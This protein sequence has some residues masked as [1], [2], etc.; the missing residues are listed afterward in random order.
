MNSWVEAE[1]SSQINSLCLVIIYLFKP[2]QPFWLCRV[3]LFP[4]LIWPI[5]I[6]Y[7]WNCGKSWM[8]L[9]RAKNFFKSFRSKHF[10]S[11]SI[12]KNVKRLDAS[13]DLFVFFIVL[14]PAQKGRCFHTPGLNES[15]RRF[16]IKFYQWNKNLYIGSFFGSRAYLVLTISSVQHV[17]T[18]VSNI[19]MQMYG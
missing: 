10:I 18:H 16:L 1:C 19:D 3:T 14:K 5:R 11:F 4:I 8:S 2:P 12:T 9:V 7:S 6:V 15:S 13:K 17:K